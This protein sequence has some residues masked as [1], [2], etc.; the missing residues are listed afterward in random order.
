MNTHNE[1]SHDIPQNFEGWWNIPEVWLEE[2][3][4]ERNG[5]SGMIRLK[6]GTNTYYIKKQCNHLYRSPSHPF[7]RP[8]V[9][10]EFESILRLQALGLCVPEPIFHGVRKTSQG[11][12]GLLV[13]RELAEF[14]ALC[15]QKSLDTPLR[16]IM[17][18]EVGRTL[19]IM[20]RAGLQHSCL[21]DKHIMIRWQDLTP[22][23]ALIDLEKMRRPVFSW[24]AA[25]HDLEQLKR[26]QFIWTDHEWGLLEQTHRI[27]L[28]GMKDG[29]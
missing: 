28:Q 13:T 23:I 6:I 4:R 12:E 15:D 8:T 16:E 9:C 5:W 14:S 29:I 26:R 7:G 22:L 21:Y 10:R 25:N 24:R 20:H 18:R 17:A 1:I 19:G 3:N 11:F 27:S 2:I